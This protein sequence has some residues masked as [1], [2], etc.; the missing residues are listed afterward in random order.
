MTWFTVMKTPA[1]D[2]RYKLTAEDIETVRR[3][4]KENTLS[5]TKRIL[6]EEYDIN[7]STA[8]IVYWTDEESRKNKR[9]KNARRKYVSGSD[10]DKRRIAR[11]ADKRRA[12]WEADPDMKL[13]HRLQQAIDENRSKRHTINFDGKTYTL[14]EAKKIIESGTLRRKN[15]KMD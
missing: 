10:E 13:R 3:L 1:K 2:R 5:Q 12:N 6:A 15:R 9:L 8:T 11:D 4:R 7:I 14:D